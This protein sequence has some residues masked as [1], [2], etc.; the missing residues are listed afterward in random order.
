MKKFA[1]DLFFNK[2]A[3]AH[4]SRNLRKFQKQIPGKFPLFKIVHI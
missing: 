4:N 3:D 2:I 1:C